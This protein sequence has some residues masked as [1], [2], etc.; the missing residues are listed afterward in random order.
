MLPKEDHITHAII[1]DHYEKVARADRGITK[2]EIQNHGYLIINCTNA[3]KSVMS[4]CAECRK[5]RG[6]I[7]QQKMGSIPADRISEEPP[8]IYCGVDG[9]VHF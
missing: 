1:R 7:C 9:L 5:L 3:V 4:K 2:N 8:F 6:R